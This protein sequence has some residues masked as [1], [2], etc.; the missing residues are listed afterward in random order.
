MGWESTLPDESALDQLPL[1][2]RRRCQHL[3]YTGAGGSRQPRLPPSDSIKY[4]NRFQEIDGKSRNHITWHQ[5]PM[6]PR[7]PP[8]TPKKK[9]NN[10]SAS[11]SHTSPICGFPTV[12]QSSRS[13]HVFTHA[14]YLSLYKRRKAFALDGR[15]GTNTANLNAVCQHPQRRLITRQSCLHTSVEQTGADHS[16]HTVAPPRLWEYLESSLYVGGSLT[17]LQGRRLDR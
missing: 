8:L 12:A 3:N 9:N 4:I 15:N 5:E 16:L 14:V 13:R 1:V 7:P 10:F 17:P 2:L 11:R 6:P